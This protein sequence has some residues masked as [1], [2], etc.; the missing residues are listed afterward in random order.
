[1]NL[2]RLKT[3]KKGYTLIEIIT[4]LVIIGIV[5]SIALGGL[6]MYQRHAAFK[7]NNEY[8]QTLFSAAQASLSHAKVS[9]QLEELREELKESKYDDNKLEQEMICLLYTSRCV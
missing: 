9:G 3:D 1:M 8:A 7:K 2:R 4:V 5:A 6:I